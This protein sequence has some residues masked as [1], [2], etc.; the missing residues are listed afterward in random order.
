MNESLVKAGEVKPGEMRTGN[1]NF[2]FADLWI[3]GFVAVLLCS[4]LIG[5]GKVGQIAGITCSAAVFFFPLSYL[6]GD[7]LTEVYGYSTAR[8]A[9]WAGFTAQIFAA[10]VSILVLALPPAEGWSH[11]AAF[12]AVFR[13][14]PRITAASLLAFFIG[15]FANSYTLAKLKIA[16]SGRHLWLRTIGSTLI[17][18]AADSLLFYPIAFLGIWPKSVLIG[19]MI[20]NYGLK[21]L[22]EVLCTP[23]TYW[24]VGALKRAE[25]H[26]AF[27]RMTDFNPFHLQSEN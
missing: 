9:V 17:G 25:H 18:E 16:T 15:E 26:D 1:Q 22:W 27:D 14:A 12:E 13:Q 10:S 4:N 3:A 5:A 8:R 6:F 24:V 19:V 21:V 7:I 2:R 23:L 20:S 11:Q